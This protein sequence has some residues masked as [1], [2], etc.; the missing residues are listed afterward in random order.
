MNSEEIIAAL[1]Y[2]QISEHSDCWGCPA[3]IG[4]T[5]CIDALHKEAADALEAQQKRIGELESERRWIPVTERLP[6]AGSMVLAV[7][8]EETIS[9]AYY[10][11]NWHSGGALEEDAVTHWMPLPEPPKEETDG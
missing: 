7:D 9:S 3:N 10:V 5:G 4:G 8:S 1:R 6:E 2:C 11:G